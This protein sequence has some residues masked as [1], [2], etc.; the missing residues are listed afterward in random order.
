MQFSQT[1]DVVICHIFTN[2]IKNR[3]FMLDFLTTSLY[4]Q[5][6]TSDTAESNKPPHERQVANMNKMDNRKLDMVFFMALETGNELDFEQ[7][8]ETAQNY[9]AKSI[10][11]LWQH[12]K[13]YKKHIGK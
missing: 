10:W 3:K 4:S 6:T 2:R 5:I 12:T 9:S 1:Q 8:K 11:K 7:I 13:R